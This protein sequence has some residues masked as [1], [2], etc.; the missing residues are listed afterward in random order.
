MILIDNP[1]PEIY[2]ACFFLFFVDYSKIRYNM[3]FKLFIFILT[4]SLEV[5]YLKKNPFAKNS[6]ANWIILC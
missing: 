4:D 6:Q 2:T 1:L 5:E 3:L